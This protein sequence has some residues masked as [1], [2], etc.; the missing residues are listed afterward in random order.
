MV[1]LE[2]TKEKML[3]CPKI[4]LIFLLPIYAI[5]FFFSQKE[6]NNLLYITYSL[7]KGMLHIYREKVN[8]SAQLLSE[9]GIY[10]YPLCWLFP[11]YFKFSCVLLCPP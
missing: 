11:A 5:H 3:L 7:F 9:E 4:C 1:G 2:N 10:Q 6:R 8:N